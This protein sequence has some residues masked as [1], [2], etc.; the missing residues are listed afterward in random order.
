MLLT[1]QPMWINQKYNLTNDHKWLN[2]HS[3]L[4]KLLQ[5]FTSMIKCKFHADVMSH[6]HITSQAT[7]GNVWT[8]CCDPHSH[9][10]LLHLQGYLPLQSEPDE[11]GSW[12]TLFWWWGFQSYCGSPTVPGDRIQL[13]HPHCTRRKCPILQTLYPL[14]T[15]HI[16]SDANNEWY[17]KSQ[18]N[19]D[20]GLDSTTFCTCK[21]FNCYNKPGKNL[22]QLHL[23][24]QSKH[25]KANS[26]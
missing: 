2:S 22:P 14:P 16:T 11:A 6:E 26:C 21:T 1:S 24:V 9:T 3:L 18:W 5:N 17:R 8:P 4:I 25:S 7:G 13:W 20:Q 15:Q 19:P 12:W 10:W 23:K